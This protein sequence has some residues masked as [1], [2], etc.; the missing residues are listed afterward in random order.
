M[1]SRTLAAVACEARRPLHG[2]VQ[3]GTRAG[4]T[5]TELT[6]AHICTGTGL[7]PAHIC[8][9]TGLAAAT[10]APGLGSPLPHLHRD[11]AHR[12]PHLRRD[13]AGDGPGP[14]GDH[15]REA[16]D[17]RHQGAGGWGLGLRAF[18]RGVLEYSRRGVGEWADA[19]HTCT[20][21]RSRRM[22]PLRVPSL[23]NLEWGT[24]ARAR[25]P[26]KDTFPAAR[27]AAPPRSGPD[28]MPHGI[29]IIYHAAL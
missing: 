19:S 10:S 29:F 11:W 22:N 18:G 26:E 5:R 17:V 24:H 16:V 23:G 1:R 2:P 27:L 8:A 9:G 4:H 21:M 15:R 3:E 28:I 12:C 25:A 7:A 14:I 13:C 6:P 20:R